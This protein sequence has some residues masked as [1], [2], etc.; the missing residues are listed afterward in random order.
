MQQ[1]VDQV[2]LVPR[3]RRLWRALCWCSFAIYECMEHK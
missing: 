2:P 3:W 1:P